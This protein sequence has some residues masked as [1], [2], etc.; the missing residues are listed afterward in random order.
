MSSRRKEYNCNTTAGMLRREHPR[1]YSKKHFT[2]KSRRSATC[3]VFR[4][5][6]ELRY[7]NDRSKLELIATTSRHAE[8][9][10][11]QTSEGQY[12]HTLYR[13]NAEF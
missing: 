12:L 5:P 10:N 1:V 11:I 9:P 4:S 7:N 3:S 13:S 2:S 8:S 6:L